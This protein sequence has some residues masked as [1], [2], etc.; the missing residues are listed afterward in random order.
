MNTGVAQ[1]EVDGK[2]RAR[3]VRDPSAARDVAD[4]PERIA[5]A[6]KPYHSGAP[7]PHGGGEVGEIL[8]VAERDLEAVLRR[9]SGQPM[10]K[11]Q[12]ITRGATTCAPGPSA[13]NSAI[14]AD[15]PEPNSSVVAAPFERAD[16]GL[17]FANRR[18]VR[19]AVDVA[20]GIAVVGIANEGRGDVQRRNQSPRSLV[21]PAQ[22]LRGD[23]AR[24]ELAHRPCP[25]NRRG[26]RC[27][28]PRRFV[29][30]KALQ[31][32]RAVD[33]AQPRSRAK[34]NHAVSLENRWSSHPCSCREDQLGDTP[35][36]LSS[37]HH[38]PKSPR[39]QRLST[40]TFDEAT[41]TSHDA[42]APLPSKQME[43]EMG[44]MAGPGTPKVPTNP[45]NTKKHWTP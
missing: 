5:R 39:P 42:G 11:P 17:G 24:A 30:E 4:A 2:G 32:R 13:R 45:R 22:R 33:K 41:A 1:V 37:I 43:Q 25:R 9:L 16:D 19:P 20:A 15:M 29:G 3:L 31:R 27:A 26:A 14:E 18:V 36:L 6:F 12:Y 10:R 38:L 35:H 8:G 44:N 23:G 21:D 28:R 40:T 7:R 34:P